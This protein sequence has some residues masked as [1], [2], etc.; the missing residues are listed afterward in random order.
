MAQSQPLRTFCP[1][2]CLKTLFL[3]SLSGE[4]D[5]GSVHGHSPIHS[6]TLFF[7]WRTHNDGC[8]RRTVERN[9][10]QDPEVKLTRTR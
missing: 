7:K 8:L 4:Q 2:F 9:H 3:L 6:S 10:K 1:L 5:H